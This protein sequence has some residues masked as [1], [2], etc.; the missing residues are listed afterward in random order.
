LDH[1]VISRTYGGRN[2]AAKIAA[3][4]GDYATAFKLDTEQ[5]LNG[6]KTSGK[7]TTENVGA[8]MRLCRENVARGVFAHSAEI[9]EMFRRFLALVK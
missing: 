3:D 4:A 6:F 1:R 2:S 9:D 7:L 5:M 8:Y